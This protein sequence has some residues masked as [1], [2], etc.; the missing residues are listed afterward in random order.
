MNKKWFTLV[1][2]VI[3]AMILAMMA[4]AL[5]IVIKQTIVFVNY[6]K[7]RFAILGEISSIKQSVWQIF[8]NKKIKIIEQTS[9]WQI[10]P[11]SLKDNAITYEIKNWIETRKNTIKD[12]LIIDYSDNTNS[13][14]YILWVISKKDKKLLPIE[15]DESW[16]FWFTEL[17]SATMT[18]I[19][20]DEFIDYNNNNLNILEFKYN[21]LNS[22]SAVRLDIN[23]DNNIEWDL[24]YNDDDYYSWSI[25]FIKKLD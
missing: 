15:S 2:L 17:K 25:H 18:W 9:T 22:W 11:Y 5:G 20:D 8:L 16:L 19:Y 14:K 7:N 21:L 3:S 23:Y 10:T 1:E 6:S 13:W 24:Q 4:V 12:I